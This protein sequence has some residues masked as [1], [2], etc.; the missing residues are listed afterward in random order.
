MAG[1]ENSRNGARSE[2]AMTRESV[3]KQSNEPA[4]AKIL[5]A[6]QYYHASPDQ[7]VHALVCKSNGVLA[8]ERVAAITSPDGFP[9]Y[10]LVFGQTPENNTEYFGCSALA[11]VVLTKGEGVAIVK[12]PNHEQPDQVY[13]Y[14][15]VLSLKIFGQLRP[16]KK[17]DP[18]AYLREFDAPV[19]PGTMVRQGRPS[20]Q[21][22]PPYAQTVLAHRL[23]EAVG[24]PVAFQTFLIEYPELDPL[25]RFKIDLNNRQQYNPQQIKA[26]GKAAA[27]C[28]PYAILI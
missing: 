21:L 15:E 23:N 28:L 1:I 22:L 20:E 3:D 9:H 8:L 10:A 12:G 14:G 13:S 17:F 27:W 7:I 19:P 24:F 26:L 11:E 25:F 2:H 5:E 18:K 6:A 16:E 4:N